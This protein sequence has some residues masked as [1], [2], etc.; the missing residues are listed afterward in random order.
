MNNTIKTNEELAVDIDNL[1]RM[2]NGEF[3]LVNKKLDKV[4]ERVENLEKRFENLDG[5]VGSLEKKVDNLEEKVDQVISEQKEMKT[6]LTLN[7]K[8]LVQ[9]LNKS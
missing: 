9:I 7:N 6:T 2:V 4:G 1:A 8:L 3:I 5:R